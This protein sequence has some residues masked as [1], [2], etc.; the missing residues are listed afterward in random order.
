MSMTKMPV[1]E[2]TAV[3]AEL[4]TLALDAIGAAGMETE[5]VSEGALIHL[6]NGYF[7]KVKI[8]VCDAE[9]FD[10]ETEREAYTTKVANAAALAE[11][12]A[13]AAAEKAAKASAKTAKATE[14]TE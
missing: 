1:K 10:L 13:L 7:A 3:R 6:A 9:K 5:I 8:S 14:V 4:Y 12:R 11:K 2:Q